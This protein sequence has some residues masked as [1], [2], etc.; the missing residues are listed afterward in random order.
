MF[1]SKTDEDWEKFGELDPYYGVISHEKFRSGILNEDARSEFFTSGEQHVARVLEVIRQRID[2]DFQIQHVLDFGCGVGR[3]VIPFASRSIS[4]TGVDVST[5]MLAEA[6][7]NCAAKGIAN[8]Q[9]GTK[10]A[11]LERFNLI[12]SFIVFQHIPPARGEVLFKELLRSLVPGGIGVVHF[13][14]GS[15]VSVSRRWFEASKRHIPFMRKAINIVRGRPALYP[16]MQM[17]KYQLPRLIEILRTSGIND[18]YVVHTDHG[19]YL[20]IVIYFNKPSV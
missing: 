2:R 15:S 13:T 7:R 17:N 20:G 9:F 12:H 10:V 6:A 8:V 3:L 18:F 4:V 16:Q 11:E 1:K 5:S 19:G 14:Y